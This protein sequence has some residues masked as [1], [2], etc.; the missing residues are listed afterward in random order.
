MAAMSTAMVGSVVIISEAVSPT[1]I[2]DKFQ[3]LNFL[4]A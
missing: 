3:L 4:Q 2:A 1:A